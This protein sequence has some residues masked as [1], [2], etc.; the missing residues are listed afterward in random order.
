MT[1]VLQRT[2]STPIGCSEFQAAKRDQRPRKRWCVQAGRC[3]LPNPCAPESIVPASI[4]V[5]VKRKK[6][7]EMEGRSRS[8][9][10]FHSS[11]AAWQQS[12]GCK[13]LCL[14]SVSL[15]PWIM[16]PA[17]G[18]ASLPSGEKEAVEV[19]WCH[20]PL[21]DRLTARLPS[22]L[23]LQAPPLRSAQASKAAVNIAAALAAPPKQA[24]SQP[25]PRAL[26]WEAAHREAPLPAL[27][28]LPPPPPTPQRPQAAAPPLHSPALPW[29]V[30]AA[31]PVLLSLGRAGAARKQWAGGGAGSHPRRQ[32]QAGCMKFSSLGSAN[33]LPCRA[34]EAKPT[35]C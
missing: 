28:A 6:Q 22:V 31:Q 7:A 14:V 23:A 17:R 11:Q 29:A 18:G 12:A 16:Q 24:P 10:P 2:W 30:A 19:Y 32:R 13:V 20:C 15:K 25:P 5:R 27:A 34:L 21:P 26:S 3:C 8:I 9:G 1:R 35:A 33:E 4:A